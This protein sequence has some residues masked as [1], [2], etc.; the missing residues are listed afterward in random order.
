[1]K[2][3]QY[4]QN[5]NSYSGEGV[6]TDYLMDADGNPIDDA[7]HKQVMEFSWYIESNGDI[8]I[9]YKTSSKS[10]FVLDYGSSQRGYFIGQED[11][12][13]YDTFYGYMIGTGN[14][15]GDVIKFDFARLNETSNAKAL[16]RSAAGEVEAYGKGATQK[17]LKSVPA[18]RFNS[19]R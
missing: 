19:R 10:T 15:N 12:K 9:Q 7:N 4:N 11:D 18:T 13:N 6:E 8:Y 1:M 14:V 17:P 5:S 16:T 3:F 2:F